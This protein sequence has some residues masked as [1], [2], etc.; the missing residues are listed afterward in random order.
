M[1]ATGLEKIF[2]KNKYSEYS[3]VINFYNSVR[4]WTTPSKNG[5]KIYK[6]LL[7]KIYKM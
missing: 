3:Y 4:R 1:Q 2:A 6:Y 7:M 5:Q